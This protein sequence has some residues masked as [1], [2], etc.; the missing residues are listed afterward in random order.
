VREQVFAITLGAGAYSDAFLAAF[1]IPNLLRDLFAEGALSTAFVPTYV[2]TLRQKSREAAFA[3]A[4]RVLSTLT[5]YLG[6]I[7][8]AAIVFPDPVVRLVAT[9]FSPDKAALCATLVQIMMPFLPT[10]SL[11]V[12]ATGALNAEEKYTAPALASSMFNI[13]A[14]IGGVA[15]W[16]WGPSPRAA[17]MPWAVL[18]LAGGVAQLA[19]QVPSLWRLGYR[20]RLLPDLLLRDA[21]EHDID[22]LRAVVLRENRPMVRLIERR[23]YAI[24]DQPDWAIVEATVSTHGDRPSWPPVHG[25]RRLLVE[26]CSGRWHADVEAWHAGWDVMACP[27]PDAHGVRTCPLLE[28]RQC[29]LVDGADAV[30][31]AAHPNDPHHDPLVAAHRRMATPVPVV[32]EATASPEEVSKLLDG[33]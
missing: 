16:L 6:L 4:N 32:D 18:A 1:R 14:I 21:G 3:L 11:A 20:P 33:A 30:V 12:V 24:V 7:A 23:G 9:G 25:R 5:I 13:V 31:V 29:P 26:S 22:N 27:G 28:G 2:A 19:I 17:V 8:V 10:I 15:V